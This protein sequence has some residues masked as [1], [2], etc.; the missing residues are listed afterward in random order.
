M[1]YYNNI[2]CDCLVLLNRKVN[3]III[4]IRSFNIKTWQGLV[5]S[6]NKYREYSIFTFYIAVKVYALEQSVLILLHSL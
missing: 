5:A 1:Q 6:L 2:M 4:I 3:I